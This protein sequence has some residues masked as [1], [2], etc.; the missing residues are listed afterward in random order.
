MLDALLNALF[1]TLLWQAAVIVAVMFLWRLTESIARA[2]LLDVAVGMLTWIPWIAA[3]VAAGWV[4]LLGCIAGQIASLLLFNLLHPRFRR[5]R[6]PTIRETLNRIVGP[7]RNHSGLWFTAPALPVFLMIRL[8]EVA[9]Y[10]GLIHILGFPRYKHSEWV[11]VSRHKFDGLVGHDLV[12]CLY[13]D[14]MTGVYSLG[15]EMLR[16]VE[17][18]WCPIRFEDPRKCENCVWDFPDVLEWA[19]SDATMADVVRLLE[20]KYPRGA[21]APRSWWGHPERRAKRDR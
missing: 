12:W 11:E 4:G 21:D 8:A 2:P 10:P 14:W 19:K 6:G 17:S 5:W 7:V 20:E 13:C 16:N 9:F 3:A 1:V 18:F 15:A